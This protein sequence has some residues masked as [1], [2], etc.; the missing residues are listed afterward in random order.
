MSELY[1]FDAFSP[2]EIAESELDWRGQGA[3]AVLRMFML[4]VLAGAFIALGALYFTVVRSDASL[5]FAVRQ[6]LMAWCFRWACCW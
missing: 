6:V 4:A 2:T 1:G 3:L 5:G